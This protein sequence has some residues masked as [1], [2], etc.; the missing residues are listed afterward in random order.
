MRLDNRRALA[1]SM[2]VGLGMLC[3]PGLGLAADGIDDNGNYFR[4]GGYVRGWAAFNLQDQPET[5]G[6][7]RGKLSMLRGSILLDA[8]ARTGPIKWKAV[9][10]LDREVKTSYLDDLESLRKTNGTTG[11]D[12]GSILNNYNN[13]D[14]REFWG[15]FKAGDRT[16]F[17]LGKQQIV[18][19]ESDFFHAMDVVHGYDL[20]WRL[21]FEGENEEWRKPLWLA[22]VKVDVPEADGQIHA[23]L[24][25]GLDRCKD[26]GNTYD[27]GGGRWFFQPYR[28]F[29]LTAVTKLDCDHPEADQDDWTGGIRW[30]GTAGSLDYSLAYIRAFAA[31][32][33]ANSA[34]APYKKAPKGAL[35]D[36]IYPQ[37]DVF[38]ATVSGYSATFD[39]VFSAEIA[40]TKDQPYNVGTGALLGLGGIKLKD[41]ITTMLR[42]DKNLNLQSLLGTNRPSFSSVQLFDV[43]VRDYEKS[44]DLARLFAFGA[45][46]PEH[47]TILT[48]FTVLNYAGDTINPGLAVGVDLTNGGGFVI[49]SVEVV[50][51]DKWR[52]KAEADL[53][54]NNGS[55]KTLFDPDRSVQLFG[56]FAKNNQFTLRLTRQF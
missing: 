46:L 38:G 1:A 47:N 37:I 6:N 51:G 40:Y 32:P 27:V 49:P 52:M 26:I 53:F 22:S 28:G 36:R 8:D 34:A 56:Y 16:T 29:D 12:H 54:W 10:R 50:L 24:R 9:G 43:W 44:D 7:D 48:A 20:S 21:F 2:A 23:Y 33:V 55:A 14:L 17:R 35:F 13:E 18:W 30:S 31:D 45:P 5:R 25:P 41:T 42:A 4:L 3:K 11:G 39:T 19:G 15:E